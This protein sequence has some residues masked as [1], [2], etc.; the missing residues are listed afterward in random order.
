MKKIAVSNETAV[1]EGC[2]EENAKIFAYYIK[3]ITDTF[4]QRTLLDEFDGDSF[5]FL[6]LDEQDVIEDLPKKLINLILPNE[7]TAILF[8]E[9]NEEKEIFVLFSETENLN[10]SMQK[11]LSIILEYYD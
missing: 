11:S 6:L 8:L 9:A 1:F 2:K 3:E 10:L 5:V 7:S 4:S